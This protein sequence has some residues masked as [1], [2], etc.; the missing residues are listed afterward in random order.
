MYYLLTFILSSGGTPPE[1]GVGRQ[2]SGLIKL[3][4]EKYFENL[5][6]GKWN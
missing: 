2:E 1:S 6:F 4:M 5:E 3:K